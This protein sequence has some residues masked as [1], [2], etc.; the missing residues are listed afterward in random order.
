M[1]D[2]YQQEDSDEIAFYL[3]RSHFQD[4]VHSVLIVVDLFLFAGLRN[5]SLF[6]IQL[7]RTTCVRNQ[8][9]DLRPVFGRLTFFMD[10]ILS[11]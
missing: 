8:N 11:V 7:P 4:R 5:V 2:P 1:M 10:F 6:P 3:H 9:M